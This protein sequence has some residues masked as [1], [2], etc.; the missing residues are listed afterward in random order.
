MTIDTL[1]SAK[2]VIPVSPAGVLHQHSIAINDG[3]ILDILPTQQA[4]QQYSP[5]QQVDCPEHALLPGLINSHTH[6]A[7]N[8]LRGIADDLP[9]M[10]WLKAHIWPAEQRWLSESF[11]HDG[12]LHAIAEM[13]RSGTTTFNDMYL[14]PDVTARCALQAGV[15]ASIGLIV[16]DFPT[17]WAQ[18]AAEYLSKGLKLRDELKNY[19]LLHFTLAPHAPYTVS[20][21]P[22]QRIAT[23]ANELDLPIHMHVHET[24]HEVDEFLQQRQQRPLAHLAALGLLSPNLQAVHMTALNAEEIELLAAHDVSVIH[25][26]ESNLKLASGIC[27]VAPLQHQG[28]NVALGTDGAA[29]NNDLDLFG[30]MRTAALLA[31]GINQDAR[32]VK[33]QTALEMATI[34]AARALHIDHLTGSLALGKSADMIAVNLNH[35][36]T[37]PVYDPV[38]TLVYACS[39]EQV[40]YV[41][42]AGRSLLHKRQLTTLDE[43]AI[44]EAAHHWREKIYA[45]NQQSGTEQ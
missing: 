35:I 31:K 24:Q 8:L 2:W 40:E 34:N 39:R 43:S 28:V 17:A 3:K 42:V 37:A 12:S 45:F 6:A 33:A 19:P 23:L 44:L 5:K 38:S 29:S 15:R 16:I 13:I 41:W 11:V 10:P 26:P 32:A 18:D 4:L 20:D 22:L 9:L 30:E 7:M 25:C 27:P 1:I 21:G 14:F 36:E